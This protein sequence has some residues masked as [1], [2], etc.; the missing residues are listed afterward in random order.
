[1]ILVVDTQVWENYGD[2]GDP[3]WKAKGGQSVKVQGVPL[4][5]GRDAIDEMVRG[6]EIANDYLTETVIG[7]AFQ[8]DGWL[9]AFEQSQLEYE[10][11]I[12]YK[13]PVIQYEDLVNRLL[14]EA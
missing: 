9:S 4:G 5:L 11:S 2:A 12:T 3:Y 6:L 1:M 7:W 14:T 10:G 13:E 8:E